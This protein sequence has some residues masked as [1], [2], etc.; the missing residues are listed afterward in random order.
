[1][2]PRQ[3]RQAGIAAFSILA[4]AWLFGS[5]SVRASR[6]RLRRRLPASVEPAR[7]FRLASLDGLMLAATY[8]P[9][10][11]ANSPGVLIVHGLAASRRVIQT[12]ADWFAARG[13]AVLTIDLRGHGLS[14]R[15]LHGFGWP[16]SLDVHAAFAWLKQHQRDAG[17]AV[18]GISMGGAA[19]LIGPRG[20]LPADALVLQAVYATFRQTV[21]NRIALVTGPALAWLTEPLLS[22][23][24]LPRLGVRPSRLSPIEAIRTVRCPVLVIGGENDGFTPPAETRA[25]FD[26]ARS[27][28]QI[29]IAPGLGHAG[30]SDTLDQAYR[31]RVLAFLRD[32]IG[33]P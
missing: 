1:M 17:V 27:R 25:L 9:G 20:S 18:I 21:R 32:T 6:F 14:D 12:N 23:Q 4:I 24:S 30:I 16:E 26:A 19:T 10:A 31:D 5:I 29:W 15:A 3:G 33:D 2:K 13:Y 7:D 28:K 11:R 8:W 22:Y